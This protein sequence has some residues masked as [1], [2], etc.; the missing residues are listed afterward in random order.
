MPDWKMKRQILQA[1]VF[2]FAA[3]VVL[4]VYVTYLSTWRS[5]E[6]AEHPLNARN[7]ATRE[8]I[9][10]GSILAADGTVLA[11][12]RSDGTRVYPLGEAAAS[13]TGYNGER[14]GGAGL[15]G[16]RNRELLGLTADMWRLGPLSQ[17]LQSDKGN[18]VVTTI[19]A[20]CQQAAYEALAGSKGAA[21]VLDADTGAVLAMV[22]LPAYDPN[23][24]E[25]DWEYL[26]NAE[27]SPL[28]NRAVQ[29]LYP[30]GSTIKPMV[31]AAALQEGAIRDGEKFTCTGVLDLGG[32]YTIRDYEGEVHGEL[33]LEQA[34]AHSC[35]VAFGGI[36]L[37]LG[38]RKLGQAFRDFGFDEEI[39]GE[40]M[41][42]RSHLPEFEELGKGDLAQ[43]AI[44]QSSL[45]VT[46]LHMALLAS[47]FAHQGE[48][49]QPFL[50]QKVVRPGGMV[51]GFNRPEKWRQAARPE[52]VG[53]LNDFMETVVESGTGTAA[54][55][56]GVR[57]TGKTG[58]A[59]NAS[60]ADHAWFIGTAELSGR[61]V[62]FAV[63]VEN[64]GSGGRTAAP[65]ARRLIQSLM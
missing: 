13:V 58:T 18:D 59:E 38:G 5:A 35:N 21:V 26:Q 33:D 52:L 65:I 42:T 60:G 61:T 4:A 34:L 1:A 31:A 29:G 47:A 2:L 15:E 51:V 64:G 17:L 27:G 20:G 6:L 54:A 30:P 62:A 10:R 57:V 3:C 24:V 28:L 37:Q 46:P 14:I 53:Q 50:V 8:E 36:G 16:H 25:A 19:D 7:A 63:I 41:M 44:G 23:S 40:I 55:V 48:I 11:S 56:Q 49:M 9:L 12:T 43:T 22:S 39:G 32:G 45:L